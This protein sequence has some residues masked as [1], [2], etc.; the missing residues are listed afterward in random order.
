MK[1]ATSL[2]VIVVLTLIVV[3]F[4]WLRGGS[5]VEPVAPRAIAPETGVKIVAFGDS[6]TAGY[7]LS[8]SESYPAQLETA[9]RA[10]GLSV[11]VINSGVS[12]ETT[13]G[14]LERAAFIRA[15][16]PDLVLL[17]IGGNDALRRLPVEETRKN[18]EETISTLQGGTTPP[19]VVLLQ[20]QAPLNA[21]LSYKRTFDNMY[22]EIAAQYKVELLPFI[23]TDVFLRNEFK[24][25]DGIHYNQAGYAE[26]VNRYL[27]PRITEIVE[28][29]SR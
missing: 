15:Q 3:G 4:F 23:T 27:L 8:V 2:I 20:M 5:S 1:K 11:T 19:V 26:V 22:E 6:L 29:M 18:I 12:G 9:L 24:L 14:N 10:A 28:R 7:G 13:R 25:S 21:G 16:N 17:G